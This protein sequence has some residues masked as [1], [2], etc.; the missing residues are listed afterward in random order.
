MREKTT[1]VTVPRLCVYFYDNTPYLLLEIRFIDLQSFIEVHLV[2]F[3][4]LRGQ[5]HA[6]L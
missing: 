5:S 1:L 2:L 3:V 6:A 4:L